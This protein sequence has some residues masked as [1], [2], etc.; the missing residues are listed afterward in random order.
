VKVLL[1]GA[2]GFLG[3]ATAGALTRHGHGV[4]ALLRPSAAPEPAACARVEVVRGDLR[5]A[6][7][8]LALAGVDAVVHLAA[9]VQGDALEQLQG[10]VLPTE[11]LLE[12]MARAGTPRLVLVSSFSVY[13]WGGRRD[14]LAE[15]APLERWPLRRDGYAVAKTWQE[16][17]CRRHADAHGVALTILRP[18]FIWGR[19]RPWVAGVGI[20]VGSTLVVNGPFRRLPLTHVESCADCVA[21]AVGCDAAKNEIVNVVDGDDVRAWRY[22]AALVRSCATGARR[23]IAL[24]YHAGLAL[25]VV[26][27]ALARVLLGPDAR[28]PGLLVPERYRARFRSFRFPHRKAASLLGWKPRA[29]AD[30][31]ARELRP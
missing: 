30:S 28:L 19:E 6:D 20:Q 18:G 25:A 13:D 12:A 2:G 24:P 16:R 8:D 11:R 7:L 17:L 29:P 3:R 27:R 5:T 10:T 22:A 1:T 4:R 26:A 9:H 14:E 31:L 23:W 21:L 15:D